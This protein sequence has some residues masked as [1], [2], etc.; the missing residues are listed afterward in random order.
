M[1]EEVIMGPEDFKILIEKL[2]VKDGDV[3]VVKCDRPV[4]AE[5]AVMIRDVFGKA[6]A[7]LK[8]PVVVL[9]SGIDL[10][11][12]EKMPTRPGCPEKCSGCHA[13]DNYW[14][15]QYCGVDDKRELTEEVKRVFQ[16]ASAREPWLQFIRETKT[17]MVQDYSGHWYIIPAAEV[18]NFLSW[19]N[20][21][22]LMKVPVA[23]GFDKYRVD[24]GPES[25]IFSGWR[26]S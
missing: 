24:G 23:E 22:R 1:N 11:V 12:L 15:C 4:A 14:Y 9:E 3:L 16:G 19:E 7:P 5:Q 25:V 20:D 10:T 18:E 13:P 8:V 2:Q 6:L 17:R 21:E 26:M